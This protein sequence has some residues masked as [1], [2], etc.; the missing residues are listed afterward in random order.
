MS[1]TIVSTISLKYRDQWTT[2]DC[3]RELVQNTLDE[4]ECLPKLQVN[5][6]SSV[7]IYD[8]GAG[9][10]KRQFVILGVSEKNSTDKRGKYG[11]GLKIA[12]GVLKRKGADITVYSN[13]WKCTIQVVDNLGEPVLAYEFDEVESTYQGVKYH[14]EGIRSSE[15]KEIFDTRF[16]PT[17]SEHYIVNNSKH[18]K[19][20]T[21]QY[22]G[23]L[24]NKRIYVCDAYKKTKYGYDL[25]N[26]KLGTDRQYSDPHS[27]G[28]EIGNILDLLED[29]DHINVLFDALQK[30]TLESDV[31]NPAFNSQWGYVFYNKY[32]H[33]AVVSDS[34][35]L[36][37]KVSYHGGKLVKFQSAHIVYGLRRLGIY[38]AGEYIR[39]RAEMRRKRKHKTFDGVAK[40]NKRNVLIAFGLV[41]KTGMFHNDFK[42]LVENNRLFFYS[43]NDGT[44]GYQKGENIYLAIDKLH[45]PVHLATIIMHEMIH[46][47]F[48]TD[49]LSEEHQ[50]YS[51]QAITALLKV[52]YNYMSP[53]TLISSVQ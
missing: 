42:S 33:N 36:R 45:D 49:D 22:A 31:K 46:L 39:G 52:V 30:D 29:H 9:M 26:M 51:D 21:G 43:S 27:I 11:E 16:L 6:S 25:H 20:M 47:E 5:G 18:G 38:E 4:L 41:Q 8:K 44:E 32:G 1:E 34:S 2:W 48:S 50:H 15:I 23:K 12:L 13:D 35:E 37:G 53:T 3:V 24:Y 40:K 10:T 14:M 19:M 7:D 28:L 17:E